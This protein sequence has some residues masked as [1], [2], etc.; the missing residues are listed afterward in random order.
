MELRATADAEEEAAALDRLLSTTRGALAL[1]WALEDRSLAEP[2]RSRAALAGAAHADG[3]ISGLFE[4][5]VP[6]RLRPKRLGDAIKPEAIL[7]LTGDAARGRRL[8]FETAAVQCKQCHR[9]GNQGT[10]LGP[11]LTEIGKKYNLAQLLESIAEPSKKIDPKFAAYLIETSSG[12]VHAGLLMEKNDREVVLKD[13][14]NKQLRVPVDEIEVFVPQQK[15]L[16]PESLLRDLTA[17]EA[18]DLLEF[19]RN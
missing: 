10:E 12:Q 5:F 19:L 14:Q 16:M 4:R 7:S 15:S 11:D 6:A 8:F 17:Q 18:A 13:A 3:Q 1:A 9:M 2:L